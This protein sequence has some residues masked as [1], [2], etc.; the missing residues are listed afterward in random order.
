MSKDEKSGRRNILL[1]VAGVTMRITKGL[2]II[3]RGSIKQIK[4]IHTMEYYIAIINNKIILYMLTKKDVND[5]LG[6]KVSYRTTMP[7]I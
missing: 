6:G 3:N 2:F 4:I 1:K 7:F 5:M